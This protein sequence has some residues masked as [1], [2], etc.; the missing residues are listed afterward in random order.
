[1]E[2]SVWTNLMNILLSFI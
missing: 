2:K 1:L